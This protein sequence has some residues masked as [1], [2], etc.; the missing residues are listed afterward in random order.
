[1]IDRS[2]PAIAHRLRHRAARAAAIAWVLIIAGCA[3][4]RFD[5]PRV[6]SQAFDQPLLTPLGQRYWPRLASAPGES[7]FRLLV[8][9]PEA[10][11]ARRALAAAAQRTL[12]LQYYIVAHDSTTTLLLDT[13]LDAARRGV[14]VR[15]L[16]DDLNVG[17]RDSE[18]AVL[19]GHPNVAVRLYNPASQRGVFGL[20]QL[21]DWL[22][23]SDRLNRRLHAK[24][25]IADGAVAVTGGR[26]LGDAYF[27][28]AP[29]RAFA[30]LDVLAAGPAVAE[31]SRSFDLYWNSPWAVPIAAIV[32]PPPAPADLEQAWAG[33]DRSAERFRDSDYIRALRQTAFGAQ[34]RSGEVPLVVAPAQVL[35]DPPVEAR[36]EGAETASSIF[37]AMRQAAET[38]R[39]ELLLVSPYLVPG[40]RGVALLCG[41]ARRGVRVRI[42]TNSLAST[43]VPLVHA[44]YA[45]YRPQMLACGVELHELRPGVAS[46]R[47][48]IGLSSGASLHSKAVVVDGELVFIGSMNLDPR[49]RHLNSELA[50]RIDSRTLGRQMTTLFDDA[51][52]LD[53]AYRVGLDEPG[54]AKAAL[55]WDAVVDGRPIRYTDEPLA[56]AWRRWF[57]RLLGRLAPEDLL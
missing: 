5:V 8:S 21:L 48:R 43:D 17:S 4:L 22:G 11:A 33:L 55:H 51:T 7:G 36:D 28:V 35:Y 50:L 9:G 56:S 1:M 30:D 26:N 24:L 38:A 27:D 52:T 2:T 40:E 45:R 3:T 13:V 39:H 37:T 31:M 16:V 12:D 18:L 6:P 29:D 23:D 54:D 44:G 41:L 25:W 34:V 53:Q 32:G 46:P 20:P 15:L 57:V 49:S 10:F 19:A 42:L 14:R 47:T